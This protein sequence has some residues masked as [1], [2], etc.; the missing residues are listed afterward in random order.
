MISL[1]VLQCFTRLLSCALFKQKPTHVLSAGGGT[2]SYTSLQI[3]KQRVGYCV[4][5]REFFA[6]YLMFN[7]IHYTIQN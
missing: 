4:S 2:T 1:E 6:N 7:F 5:K 3:V